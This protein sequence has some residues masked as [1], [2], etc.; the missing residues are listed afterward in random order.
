MA[1]DGEAG[2]VGAEPDVGGDR[3]GVARAAL[4]VGGGRPDQQD[5]DADD[6]QTHARGPAGGDGRRD[7]ERTGARGER[8][9]LR[10]VDV[11]RLRELHAAATRDV[12]RRVLDAEPIDGRP[13]RMRCAG[14]R[15]RTHPSIIT[16]A[17]INAGP[18][19]QQHG[20]F[21]DCGRGRDGCRH[22]PPMSDAG[23]LARRKGSADEVAHELRGLARGLADADAG[24]LEGLLLSRPR[25]RTNRTR[26]R[27][28]D[29]S[30]CPRG[31]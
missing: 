8:R 17:K 6:D 2:V 10:A 11:R 24:G 12:G 1:V 27:P 31:R 26:S 23:A 25:C 19:R 5:G 30:S 9:E 4:R 7:A 13:V 16:A 18:T 14:A 29:P 22:V 15:R 20:P 21:R 28:R 3:G